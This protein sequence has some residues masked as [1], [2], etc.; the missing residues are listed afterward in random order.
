M[1]KKLIAAALALCLVL[2]LLP[3][4]VLAAQYKGTLNG[5]DITIEVGDDGSYTEQAFGHYTLA[6]GSITLTGGKLPGT[7]DFQLHYGEAPGPIVPGTLVE[8]PG[9]KEVEFAPTADANGNA[10]VSASDLAD[11]G[12]NT[13]T[14]SLDLTSATDGAAVTLD[15]GLVSALDTNNVQTVTVETKEVVADVP[16]E[17]LPASGAAKIEMRPT[18]VGSTMLPEGTD[19]KV[20]AA[21]GAAKAVTVKVTDG[22]GQPLLPKK[23]DYTGVPFITIQLKGLLTGRTY[24][25][26]CLSGSELTRFGRFASISGSSLS[27]KSH[28][29]SDFIAVEETAENAAA[30]AAVAADAGNPDAPVVPGNTI[31]I[32][33]V[34]TDIKQFAKIKVSGMDSGKVYLIVVGKPT[35]GSSQSNFIVD[36]LES[37]EFYCSTDSSKQTI[38][39]Y[40]FASK[41]A[42]ATDED[43]TDNLKLEK[44][45]TKVTE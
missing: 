27:I 19:A 15:A 20:V 13:E 31:K 28:H 2:G 22:A 7:H 38:A 42:I 40:E 32:D 8:T 39:V 26:L 33:P 24:V 5:S 37:Y 43:L 3:M 17:A 12:E 34:K 36:N 9:E 25:V 1:K 6:P 44:E 21:V 10:T 4:S 14:V 45:V 41:S 30:L 35:K 18:T 11:L 16:V 29:L 23:A